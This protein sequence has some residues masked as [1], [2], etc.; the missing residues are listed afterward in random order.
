MYLCFYSC[1]ACDAVL[2]LNQAICLVV[3]H[4]RKEVFAC[5]P[6]AAHARATEIRL[7]ELLSDIFVEDKS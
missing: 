3:P 5:L 4:E 2:P 6:C 7:H 1:F